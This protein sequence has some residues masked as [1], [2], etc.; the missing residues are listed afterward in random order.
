MKS[1][2]LVLVCLVCSCCGS[3]WSAE[4]PNDPKGGAFKGRVTG[5]GEEPLPGA[6]VMVE[7]LNV[8]TTSDVDGFYSLPNLSPGVYTI[9]F[10]YVGYQPVEK[11]VTVSGGRTVEEN[12]SLS[13]GVSLKDVQVVG[14]FTG[15]KRT[16]QMQKGKMGVTNVVSSDQVGRFPDF[17]YRRRAETY[18]RRE[19]AV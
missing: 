7:G 5:E 9:K 12:I 15:E 2:L 8:G 6:V 10:S 13:E 14:A 4:I 11:T 3:A 1:K 19:R 16:L 17:Q 18:Q